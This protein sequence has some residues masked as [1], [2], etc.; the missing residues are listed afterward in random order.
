MGGTAATAS[1]SVNNTDVHKN[2]GVQLNG[3]LVALTFTSTVAA[4]YALL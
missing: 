1:I 4:A 2:D 3:G